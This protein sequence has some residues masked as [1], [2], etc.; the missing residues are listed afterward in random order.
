MSEGDTDYPYTFDTAKANRACSFIEKL[1]HVKGRWAAHRESLK[2]QP[3][4]LFIVCSLFGW[5]HRESGLRKY[6][7]AF[8]LVPRKNG[9]SPLAAAIGLYMLCADGEHGA[10]VYCGA[11]TEAQAHEVFRPAQQMVKKTPA[12]QSRLGVEVNAKSL[13]VQA[14]SSRFLPVIGKPGDGAAPSCGICDEFHEATTADLYDTFRTGMVGREQPLL[15]VVTTAGFDVASPCHALQLE[16]EKMLEGVTDDDQLFALIFTCDADDD[17]GSEL[18]LR[19]ANPNYGISVNSETLRHDQQIALGNSA[20]QNTFK[21][22]H[23]NIWCS[24]STAWMNLQAWNACADP[25]LNE[26]D[27][28]DAECVIGLDLAS[29]LDIAAAVKLFRRRIEGID[30]Y[31]AFGSWYLPEERAL[32][33]ECQH[34]QQWVHDGIL[35]ATPGN[36]IDY[37]AIAAD[38][39]SDIKTYQ[40][41]ELAFDPY[42]ATHLVQQLNAET[43][44]VT[45]E[46]PQTVKTLSEPMKQFEALVIAGRFHHTGDS[47]FTWMVSNVVAHTDAKDNVYPR[48]DK[49]ESKIDGAVATITALS[50]ALAL[51][52]LES[53][54]TQYATYVP[55]FSV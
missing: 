27:F 45:V 15:L 1:P 20:K 19:K 7:Q 11:T 51:P 30:H 22:K 14:T 50:R 38:L 43:G 55:L 5:V 4:Q 34:Y 13:V 32:R 28:S 44:V 52:T 21:T 41:R 37:A 35:T 39:T 12:L 25:T 9:K 54:R 31:F 49:P 46:V 48:K 8:L 33:P 18:A 53:T 42:N 16:A 40:V 3:W 6:R 23:L 2:L 24:A 47:A 29:K 10:E 26:D 17:W 36:V